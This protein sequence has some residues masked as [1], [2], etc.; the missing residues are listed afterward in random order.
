MS[1]RI[2]TDTD[3]TSNDLEIARTLLRQLQEHFDKMEEKFKRS[4]TPLNDAHE[5]SNRA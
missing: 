1:G 4:R 2:S 5:V 3:V